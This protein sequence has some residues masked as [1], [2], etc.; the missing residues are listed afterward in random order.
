MAEFSQ[1]TESHTFSTTAPTLASLFFMVFFLGASLPLGIYAYESGNEVVQAFAILSIPIALWGWV[2][3]LRKALRSIDLTLWSLGTTKGSIVAGLVALV[4]LI[5]LM[6]THGASGL[7]L[8]MEIGA[9]LYVL[10]LLVLNY[11]YTGSVLLTLALTV[12]HVCISA[13][14]VV[15]AIWL[16]VRLQGDTKSK[17]FD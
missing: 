9:A 12:T 4:A 17:P 8:A 14:F 6:M 16:Y 3:F 1:Q 10:V 7:W 11:R 5:A 15:F 13:L 2:S